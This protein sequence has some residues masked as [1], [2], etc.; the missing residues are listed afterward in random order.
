[1]SNGTWKKSTTASRRA[2]RQI[3]YAHVSVLVGV[4]TDKVTGLVQFTRTPKG[5]GSTATRSTPRANKR[6]RVYEPPRGGHDW[7]GAYPGRLAS[8]E[9]EARVRRSANRWTREETRLAM[10]LLVPPSMQALEEALNE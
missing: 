3:R 5:Q 10:R 4:S 2:N 9:T 6:G 1:M 7:A 8:V